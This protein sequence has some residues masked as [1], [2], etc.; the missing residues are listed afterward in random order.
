MLHVFPT[1]LEK[2][3]IHWG[4]GVVNNEKSLISCF[5]CVLYAISNIFR[6]KGG[7]GGSSVYIDLVVIC[8]SN[9]SLKTRR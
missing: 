7:G 8:V 9:L 4:L 1:F 6:I 5:V 2:K 3:K